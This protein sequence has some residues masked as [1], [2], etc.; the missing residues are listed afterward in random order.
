MYKGR[1]SEHCKESEDDLRYVEID[2]TARYG[3]V[4]TF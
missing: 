1:F 4:S 3:R 2:P